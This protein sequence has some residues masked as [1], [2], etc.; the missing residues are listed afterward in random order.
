MAYQ[1]QQS[2]TQGSYSKTS[3]VAPAAGKGPTTRKP[4]LFSTGLFSPTKEGVKAIGSVQVKE[5]ITIPAGSYINLYENDK[6]P[7]NGGVAPAFRLQVTEGVLK[8]AK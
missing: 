7:A 3:S 8:S 6:A 1:S 5:A 2:R 4:A